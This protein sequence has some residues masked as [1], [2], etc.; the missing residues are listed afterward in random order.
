MTGRCQITT[1]RRGEQQCVDMVG[2]GYAR[3]G[4]CGGDQGGGHLRCS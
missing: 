1:G 3:G 4:G 2:I